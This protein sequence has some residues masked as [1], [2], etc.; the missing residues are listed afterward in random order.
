M[1]QI[2][3]DLSQS[4]LHYIVHNRF[5]VGELPIKADDKKSVERWVQG[6]HEPLVDVALFERAQTALQANR[7]GAAKVRRGARRYVLTG[8][9]VCGRCGSAMHCDTSKGRSRLHCYRR[10]KERGCTQRIVQQ[11]PVEVQ[12][13]KLLRSIR[14]P[15]EIIPA[16][17]NSVSTESRDTGKDRGRLERRL[18]KIRA[19]YL[20]D[21]LT[22]GEYRTE[23][24]DIIRQLALLDAVREPIDPT[25][26]LMRYLTNFDAWYADATEEERNAMLN[27]VVTSVVVDDG[28]VAAL[29]LVPAADNM[30]QTWRSL[31]G[32]WKTSNQ[33]GSAGA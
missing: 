8:L 13:L 10:T 18:K 22:E 27:H 2:G 17:L 16:L 28:A 9:C 5:Y 24:E 11:Q 6:A 21:D 19:L 12:L 32:R 14:P 23:K 20:D 31:A 7:R 26:E 4:S 25:A 3:F 33:P 30:V 29:A 15:S 1:R